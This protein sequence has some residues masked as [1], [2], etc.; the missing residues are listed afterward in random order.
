MS[1]SYIL[2]A[3]IGRHIFSGID[4]RFT[5]NGIKSKNALIT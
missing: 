1:I 2:P 4:L 5:Q 3:L